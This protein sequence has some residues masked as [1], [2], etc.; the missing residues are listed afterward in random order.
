MSRAIMSGLRNGQRILLHGQ[1][2]T[3]EV[4]KSFK[5]SVFKATTQETSLP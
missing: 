3:Y 1:K 2:G 4:V 5:E